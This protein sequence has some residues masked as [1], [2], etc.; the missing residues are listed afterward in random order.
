M[1]ESLRDTFTSPDGQA[2]R[3]TLGLAAG[4]L[5][6]LIRLGSYLP[7]PAAAQEQLEASMPS[8]DPAPLGPADGP[9]PPDDLLYLLARRGVQPGDRVALMAS[10]RPEWIVAVQA[11][12]RLGA[13]VVLFSPAWKRA[14]SRWETPSTA[15]GRCRSA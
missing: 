11:V 8:P 4:G 15:A 13:A 3:N 14:A 2:M 1:G 6:A 10:N 9:P 5:G 7:G 12:R